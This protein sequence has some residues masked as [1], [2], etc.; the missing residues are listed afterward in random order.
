MKKKLFS[1]IIPIFNVEEYIKK[2]F[3]NIFSQGIDDDDFEIIAVNDGTPD[4]SM[5]YVEEFKKVH[6]NIVTINKSNGGVS[7]ARNVGIENAKGKYLIFLD[8][9][10]YFADKSLLAIKNEVEQNNVDFYVLRSHKSSNMNDA[11]PWASLFKDKSVKSGIEMYQANYVRGSVCGCIFCRDFINRFNIRFY[12]RTRNC[13]DTIFF[14]LC[15]IYAERIM[16]LNKEFYVVY[17]RENSASRSMSEDKILLMFNSLDYVQQ[18]A[19][20]NN[21]T[22]EL[23]LDMLETLRYLLISNLVYFCIWYNGLK[24]LSLLREK[25]IQK[26]LP[27]KV[28]NGPIACGINKYYTL[29]INNAFSLYFYLRLFK[30]N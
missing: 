12:E 27:I 30:F 9:D 15:Q 6:D 19:E 3:D 26:Y 13:E 16:F 21:I 1:I 14:F 22:D 10:D 8:P 11:Y 24:S 23:A 20:Q 4:K 18:Y 25:K 17:E 2:C 28:K 7:S 29:L 5:D